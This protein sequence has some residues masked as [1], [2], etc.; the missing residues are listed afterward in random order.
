MPRSA[1]RGLVER[2]ADAPD[3]AAQE[4]VYQRGRPVRHVGEESR[5]VFWGGPARPAPVERLDPRDASEAVAPDVLAQPRQRLRQVR[6]YH[7]ARADGR[8]REAGQ[9]AACAAT[10]P[11]GSP[12]N[13][14]KLFRRDVQEHAR[15]TLRTKGNAP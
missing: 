5:E 1:A 8:G 6:E 15:S 2:A 13:S 11:A 3:D 10:D 7:L 9:A 12:R 4:P 14:P